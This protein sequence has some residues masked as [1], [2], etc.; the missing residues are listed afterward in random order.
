MCRLRDKAD[1]T[2]NSIRSVSSVNAE[3]LLVKITD[4]AIHFVFRSQHTELLHPNALPVT[5]LTT[6]KVRLSSE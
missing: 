5:L 1:A 6:K 4:D 2:I 3:T